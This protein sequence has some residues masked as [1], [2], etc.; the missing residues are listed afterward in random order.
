LADLKKLLQRELKVLP[1]GADNATPT[2]QPTSA[3]QGGSNSA[4]RIDIAA[5]A[6]AVGVHTSAL[7]HSHSDTA[8][9]PSPATL[10]V[11]EVGSGRHRNGVADGISALY[12]SSTPWPS[13]GRGDG[14]TTSSGRTRRTSHRSVNGTCHAPSSGGVMMSPVDSEYDFMRE[15]NFKYLRHVVLKFMLSRETEVCKSFA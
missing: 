11:S 10:S 13:A 8:N 3:E 2:Y 7:H 1:P 4:L 6:A 9:P 12:G 14:V 5:A 15:L